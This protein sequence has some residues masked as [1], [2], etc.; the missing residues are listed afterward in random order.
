VH[1]LHDFGDAFAYP[2]D[3]PRS[4]QFG[5]AFLRFGRDLEAGHVVTIEPGVYFI[6]ALIDR[7]QEENRHVEFI[8]FDAVD[9]YRT[10]GGIRIEDD[11]LCTEGGARVLG[12]AIPKSVEAVEEAM[13]R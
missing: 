13:A 4:H 6:P 5:L 12:T 2:D 1:D 7:W 3:Q 9:R 8:D 10:F 11:V